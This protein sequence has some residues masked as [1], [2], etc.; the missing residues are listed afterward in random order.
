MRPGPGV[1][2]HSDAGADRRVVDA[3]SARNHDAGGLKAGHRLAS[4][5]CGADTDADE[6]SGMDR[7]G[8]DFDLDLPGPWRRRFGDFGGFQ[9][10][11]RLAGAG[12][13]DGAYH[14]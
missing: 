10:V 7:E 6:V 14:R 4:G 11:G 1:G 13:G 5:I 9:D 12:E 3:G 8:A 2:E